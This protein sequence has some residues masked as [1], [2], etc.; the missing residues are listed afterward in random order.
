MYDKIIDS[1]SKEELLAM[2]RK[3]QA[4]RDDLVTENGKL[5]S[6]L[7]LAEI[8]IHAAQQENRAPVWPPASQAQSAV[9]V[10]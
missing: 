3:A 7:D 1:A 10:N 2:A 8:A 5:D 6:R 9:S 4:E